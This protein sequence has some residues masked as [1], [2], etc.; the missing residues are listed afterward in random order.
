MARIL[1]IIKDNGVRCLP[2]ERLNLDFDRFVE[3]R[4]SDEH[5]AETPFEQPALEGSKKRVPQVK[6][7]IP[8]ILAYFV[9]GSRRTYKVADVV[10]EGRYLPIV[11]G[12]V[13][14]AVVS[15]HNGKLRP[16]RELCSMRNLIAFPD[17]LSDED[18]AHLEI[19]I[20]HRSREPFGVVKYN[21]KPDRDPVDL[22]VAKIMSEMH[23]MEVA[24][25]VKM[26]GLHMLG[27]DRLLVVDGPLRFKKAFDVVQFR[28]VIGLSKSFR[29]SFTVGRGKRR[30]DVGALTSMLDFGERTSTFKIVDEDKVLG[31]WYLR[32][33]YPHLMPSPLDGVVKLECYAVDPQEKEEGFEGERIDVISG[34]VLRERN[35]APYG[36]DSRW[37]NHLYPV[38]MA[39]A[40]LR[41]SFMSTATFTALF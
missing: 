9:D 38:Y 19:E 10:L 37:A 4:D 40:Y 24:T 30:V 31:S 5:P 22:G 28:N 12:Q 18:L 8:T 27:N 39:E 20:N 21:V 41:A 36:S 29:P 2:Y 3:Y 23:S 16:L 33:R 7:N 15:R 26:A 11:A 34:H 17:R 6:E 14:V 13:G 1:Q 25:V 32:L 35:V